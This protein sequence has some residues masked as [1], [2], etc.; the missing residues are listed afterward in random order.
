METTWLCAFVY[1]FYY[2]YILIKDKK[3]NGVNKYMSKSKYL[4]D[5]L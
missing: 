4:P 1:A 3:N 5:I 2:S